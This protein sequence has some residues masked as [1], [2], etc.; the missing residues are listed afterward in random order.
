[1]RDENEGS[2]FRLNAPDKVAEKSLVSILL[3]HGAPTVCVEIE[4]VARSLILDT[5]SNISILQPEVSRGDVMVISAKP[6]GVTGKVLDIR[7]Q[8]FPLS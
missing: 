1:V 8:Q 2:S 5:G 7:G 4:G 3:E 6:Y